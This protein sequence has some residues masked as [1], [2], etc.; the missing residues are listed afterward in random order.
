MIGFLTQLQH[1]IELA[2]TQLLLFSIQ[3]YSSLVVISQKRYPTVC[4]VFSKCAN[5]IHSFICG[6]RIEPLFWKHCVCRLN[7]YPPDPQL[8]FQRLNRFEYVETYDS[9]LLSIQ[10]DFD[11]LHQKMS[12]VQTPNRMILS[13]QN[14]SENF[15]NE[16]TKYRFLSVLY[17]DLFNNT[18]EIDVPDSYYVIGNELLGPVWIARY[19]TYEHPHLPIQLS[20]TLEVMDFH[21]NHFTLTST[22]HVCLGEETYTIVDKK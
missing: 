14:F 6:K 19:L 12:L 16:E 21:L 9:P 20:Y 7:V 13:G 8:F 17:T 2:T 4:H 10:E 15:T 1:T 5:Q 11:P 18:I 3:L 22:Q